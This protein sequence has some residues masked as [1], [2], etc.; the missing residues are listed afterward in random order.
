MNNPEWSAIKTALYIC[1]AKSAKRE[2]ERRIGSAHKETRSRHQNA[3]FKRETY[4]NVQLLFFFF[5]RRLTMFK[6][7]ASSNMNV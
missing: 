3:V 5:L 2:K 7:D 4:Y 6:S 1:N